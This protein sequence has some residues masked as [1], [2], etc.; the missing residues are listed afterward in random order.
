MMH[1]EAERLIVAL[2]LQRH[3]EGGWY[4]ET[5]RAG[6]EVRAPWGP[7]PAG[8][9][10]LYLL[11]DGAVSRLH[12][13]K[14]DEIWYLHRGGPVHLRLLDAAG[15]RT[16]TL[17]AAGEAPTFQAEAPGGT[18]FGAELADPAG[19][20]LLGCAVAPG[21]DFADFELAGRNDL[22]DDYPESSEL[23]IRLTREEAA[24]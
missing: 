7:R 24:E 2:D 15:E 20:A 23:V 6:L 22:I 11:A 9:S 17:D 21:F 4:R 13:L 14:A 5:W 16:R 10:I 3:P 1:P 12:R 19:F 8:T 18:W